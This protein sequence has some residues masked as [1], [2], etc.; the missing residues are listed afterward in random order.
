MS[1]TLC[2]SP[3]CGENDTG[4]VAWAR[5]ASGGARLCPGCL[6]RFAGRL[7]ELPT[8]Y[9]HCE[10]LLVGSGK[11]RLERVSGGDVNGIVLGDDLVSART[12]IVSVLASWAALVAD[13]RPVAVRPARLVPDLAVF[14]LKHLAWLAAHPAVRDAVG[15]IVEAVEAARAALGQ[16]APVEVDLGSCSLTGCDRPVR[17]AIDRAQ[18]QTG[19]VVS[20]GA[21]HV[22][23]PHE[24]L[25]LRERTAGSRRTLPAGLA[26]LAAGVPAATVRKW[27]SRG[28]LTRYGRPGRAQ[29]DIEE[30]F[31]LV[32]A[33]KKSTA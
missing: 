30:I 19:R 32:S 21:G 18:S 31:G 33:R 10:S 4:G 6:E 13:E 11:R 20:C 3:V 22:V 5:R 7:C 28:K 25:T 2:G 23:P 17:A 27:A 8:L 24:W 14:L 9:A 12:R 1:E 16:G 15:E 29:Y 26:A